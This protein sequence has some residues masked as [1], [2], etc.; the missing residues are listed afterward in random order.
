MLNAV[1]FKSPREDLVP[2]HHIPYLLSQN[3]ANKLSKKFTEVPQINALSHPTGGGSL[4]FSVRFFFFTMNNME[5][6][7]KILPFRISSSNLFF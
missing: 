5:S 3:N 6:F 1:T 2:G 7:E 4:P